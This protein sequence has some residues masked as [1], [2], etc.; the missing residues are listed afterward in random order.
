MS[1]NNKNNI[2]ALHFVHLC[3]GDSLLERTEIFGSVTQTVGFIDNLTPTILAGRFCS[4]RDQPFCR[5]SHIMIRCLRREDKVRFLVALCNSLSGVYDFI[6]VKDCRKVMLQ[7]LSCTALSAVQNHICHRDKFGYGRKSASYGIPI[8]CVFNRTKK[9]I[10]R[11]CPVDD[12]TVRICADKFKMV[13]YT[14][15]NVTSCCGHFF[16]PAIN[17]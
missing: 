9:C 15:L 2:L 13:I 12:F 17:S 11:I 5:E 4:Q 3:R 16:S 8:S 1:G 10:L 6:A 7:T 14:V